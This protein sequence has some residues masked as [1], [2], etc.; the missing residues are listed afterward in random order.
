MIAADCYCCVVWPSILRLNVCVGLS[1][2]RTA[3][4]PIVPP[5]RLP[6]EQ[7]APSAQ[8]FASSRPPLKYPRQES[9][10]GDE[11]EGVGPQPRMLHYHNNEPHA[12]FFLNFILDI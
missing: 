11:Y 12:V 2:E 1:S 7:E 4:A 5:H 3:P 9:H 8:S 6:H 10:C